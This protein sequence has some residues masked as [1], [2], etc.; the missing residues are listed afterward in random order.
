MIKGYISDPSVP[1]D[2]PGR[3]RDPTTSSL[4]QSHKFPE[5]ADHI[6][7]K[8]GFHNLGYSTHPSPTK[9]DIDNNHINRLHA[10]VPEERVRSSQPERDSSRYILRPEDEGTPVKTVHDEPMLGTEPSKREERFRDS[11]LGSGGISEGSDGYPYGQEEEYEE[12]RC[13]VASTPDT[14]SM[15]SVDMHTSSTSLSSAD[16]KLV[17]D[18]RD[19][20]EPSFIGG[21]QETEKESD[22]LSITDS[23]VA[24][25]LAALDAA[26]A[27]EDFE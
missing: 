8:Q 20:N 16:T 11:G 17:I 12:M 26:T 21:E 23:M 14:E 15:L 18:D 27:G 19:E 5:E 7:K 25:A 9:L 24:E 2:V 4:Y 22:R 3:K 10:N 1:V 13:K 6:H